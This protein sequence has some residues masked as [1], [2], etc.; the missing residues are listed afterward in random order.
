MP[1][2]SANRFFA[3]GKEVTRGT[4]A[5]PTY[6]IPIDQD[7]SLK[8]N[9]TWIEDKGIRGSATSIYDSVPGVR[10]DEFDFKGNLYADTFPVVMMG[11]LGVDT[12][13]GTGAPYTHTM[14]LLEAAS[15]G[16]QPASYTGID[17]DNVTQTGGSAKQFT[18]GQFGDTTVTFSVDA[19]LT[20]STKMMSN[21][22]SYVSA[23]TP[24]FSTEVF[25]PSWSAS[26]SVGGLASQ[27]L[28]SGNID[29]KRGTTSI[30]TIGQQAP[31]RIWSGPLMVSGKLVFVAEANETAYGNALTRAQQVMALT[32]TDPV[33][34]HSVEFQMSNIQFKTP[35]VAFGKEYITIEVDYQSHANVTDGS[36]G[37]S[38]LKFIATNG[39][40]A[41]Y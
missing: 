2:L 33:S 5:L 25:I 32:F 19:A 7:A 11:T 3:L 6:F 16:S 8:P 31:Y 4:A 21:P 24:S 27:V 26:V 34:S 30:P 14:T 28:I 15:S 23:P 9:I 41:S 1:F 12:V 13:T 22:F 29:I 18:A 20:Y 39:V 10:H 40:S 38:P 35:T 17:V 37:Y 36:T